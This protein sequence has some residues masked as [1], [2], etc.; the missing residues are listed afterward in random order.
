MKKLSIIFCLILVCIG[1]SAQI[2]PR[3]VTPI[4]RNPLP[5]E[6]IQLPTTTH[7]DRVEIYEQPNF[8]GRVAKYANVVDPFRYPFTNKRNISLKVAPGHVAYIKFDDEFQRTLICTGDYPTFGNVFKSNILSITIKAANT[9][10]ISFSGFSLPI[11]N[12]DCKKMAGTVK[13]RLIE[14]LADGSYVACPIVNENGTA[15]SNYKTQATM[16]SKIGL[17]RAEANQIRD[18]IFNSGATVPVIS[19]TV[20]SNKPAIKAVFMVSNYALQNGNIFVEVVPNISVGHKTSDLATDYS[21]NVK[22]LAI[23]TDL[24]NYKNAGMYFSSK[25]FTVKGN[26]DNNYGSASGVAYSIIK[27][28]RIHFSK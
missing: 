14:K 11:H 13:V 18:F 26:P 15:L 2:N 27:D 20:A 24:I 1:V 8:A 19:S 3:V 22:M 6:A 7:I 28:F 4:D 9:Q 16:F 23:D 21:S 5:I 10:N 25:P 17:E 12:N